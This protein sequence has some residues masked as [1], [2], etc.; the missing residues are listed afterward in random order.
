MSTKQGVASKLCVVLGGIGLV[1]GVGLPRASAA[2]PIPPYTNANYNNRY[3]CNVSTRNN[4]WTGTMRLL[5]NGS[6]GYSVGTLAASGAA[7]PAGFFDPTKGPLMRGPVG[8]V[9]FHWWFP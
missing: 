5:P 7:G 2:P 8:T 6:G 4:T 9:N 1:V 3:E